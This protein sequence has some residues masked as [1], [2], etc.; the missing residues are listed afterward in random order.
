MY[1]GVMMSVSRT[2]TFVGDL[3]K[4]QRGDK[5]RILREFKVGKSSP[6]IVEGISVIVP[7]SSPATNYAISLGGIGTGE[8]QLLILQSD[9]NVS[10][11]INGTSSTP[12]KFKELFVISGGEVSTV[13][14]LNESG[15]EACVELWAVGSAVSS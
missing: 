5:T 13:H 11:R 3:R 10:V 6:E 4:Y 8:G 9:R 15:S 7:N 1:W 14:I 12:I 2:M